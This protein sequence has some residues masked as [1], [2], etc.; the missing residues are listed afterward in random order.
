MASEEQ[1]TGMRESAT[2]LSRCDVLERAENLIQQ[3]HQLV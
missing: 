2:R 1:V 3:R